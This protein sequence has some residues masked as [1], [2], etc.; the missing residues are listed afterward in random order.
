MD[1]G[2]IITSRQAQHRL[3]AAAKG[4]QR[5]IGCSLRAGVH[6]ASGYMRSTLISDSACLVELYEP[7]DKREKIKIREREMEA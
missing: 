4:R 3:A 7:R 1:R 5:M 2:G 6:E